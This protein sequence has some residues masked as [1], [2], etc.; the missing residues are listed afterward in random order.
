MSSIPQF[1]RSQRIV[2]WIGESLVSWAQRQA[3]RS[4]ARRA[5]A[6][7]DRKHQDELCRRAEKQREEAILNFLSRR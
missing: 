5:A 1:S 7:E 3:A 2:L 6:A 4:E